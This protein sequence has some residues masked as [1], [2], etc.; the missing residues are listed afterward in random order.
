MNGL[1][2][3]REY[4]IEHNV[5]CVVNAVNS[6]HPIDV[7]EFF[8][9]QDIDWIQLIPL[10]E[11][12]DGPDGEGDTGGD[13]GGLPEGERSNEHRVPNWVRKRGG[14]V[15]QHD[16]EHGDVADAARSAPVTD[17]SVDPE[18]YG[19][20]MSRIFDEWI[21]NDIGDVS[22]CLFDQCLETVF[23]GEASLCVFQETCGDQVAMEYN[24]DVYAC[25]H[26]VDEGFKRGNVHETHLADVVDAPEQRQFGEYKRDGLPP[27]CRTCNVR[28]FCHGGCPKNPHLTTPRGEPGLNYLCAGYRY[29]F[30]YVQPYLELV[31]QTV[32]RGY[33]L[34]F[35]RDGVAARD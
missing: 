2:N 35:V 11:P 6:Q 25:D 31:E 33:P 19:E 12:L 7:Y 29:F 3:L 13:A 26:Y 14:S 20:F 10:V 8:R 5:L 24:G 32:K 21:R 16:E 9:G 34:R 27:R 30:T 18:S 22:V 17:R 15:A 23:R 1:S 4:D 28:E